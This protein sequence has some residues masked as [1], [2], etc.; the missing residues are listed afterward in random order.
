M[1]S[2]AAD[3]LRYADLGDKRLTK[4]LVRLTE[5]IAEKPQASL[6]EAM[7]RWAETK[8]A[9]RFFASEE[10]TAAEIRQAHALRTVERVKEAGAVL[11]IQDTTELDFTTH[12]AT[13]GLGVL[14]HPL[15][16]GMKVHTAL[17]VSLAGVPLGILHQKV[18]VRNEETIGKRHRRHHLPTAEKESQR[19]L[20][21]EQAV[22]A[23][24]PEDIQGV[25]IADREG[26]IFDYLAQGRR[27][28]WEVLIRAAQD[29][30]VAAEA[31]K[32][33]WEV[34]R[35]QPIGGEMKVE[36]GRRSDRLPREARV[37]LRWMQIALEPP[38]HRKGRKQLANIPVS[39]IWV[40]EMEP[41][42]GEAGLSWLLITTLTVNTLAEAEQCV[43]WYALRWL[44]ERN[45]YVLKSGC[46]VEKLQLAEEE[47]LERAV[48]VYQIVAWRLLWLTYEA[49]RNPAQSCEAVLEREEWQAL[50][51]LVHKTHQP[52]Q[53]PPSLAEAIRWIA[54]LGGFLARKA[55]GPPGVKTLWR[56]WRT[57]QVATEMF[58]VLRNSSHASTYG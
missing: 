34:I 30:R 17:A 24:L 54:Q 49:R 4:R 37:S 5:K 26:D 1:S 23:L 11:V 22:Q 32:R 45:H 55:D 10:Y 36:V 14:S 57:L 46:Q 38:L 21:S 12:R 58:R 41:P 56:G 8:A 50:Y 33:L 52:P 19:W 47:R 18:W 20:E 35:S 25:M 15:R 53:E 43:R 9:Y 7:G 3:E 42:P 2:W 29:R 31:G 44:I 13:Q 16:R 27:A 51:C 40:E 39:V 28:G 48:A 6:P